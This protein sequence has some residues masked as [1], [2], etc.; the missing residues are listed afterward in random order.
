MLFRIAYPHFLGRHKAL[1]LYHT[2]PK[3]GINYEIFI[4]LFPLRK[5]RN[6]WLSPTF[7]YPLTGEVVV[8]QTVAILKKL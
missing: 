8:W 3:R 5:F 1:G 7:I 4:A 2:P 6:E